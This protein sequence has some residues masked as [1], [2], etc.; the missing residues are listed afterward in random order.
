MINIDSDKGEF[1]N[2]GQPV[3][4]NREIPYRTNEGNFTLAKDSRGSILDEQPNHYLV[5]VED[6]H[7]P[8]RVLKSQV[9]LLA[10]NI[11]TV[12]YNEAYLRSVTED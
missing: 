8:V 1:G 2:M 4:F 7:L 12:P 9:S 5:D 6:L 3:S 11:F 10:T